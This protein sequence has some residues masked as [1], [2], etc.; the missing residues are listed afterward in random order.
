MIGNSTKFA[1]VKGKGVSKIS[2]MNALDKAMLSAGIGDINMIKVSS[3][4]PPEIERVEDFPDDIGAFRPCVIAK[5]VGKGKDLGAGLA[6]GFR[7]DKKGGYVAENSQVT[8]NFDMNKF[9]SR[10][11]KKITKMG[12]DRDIE[13]DG[14][15]TETIELKVKEDEF[16]C[17]LVVLVYLP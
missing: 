11:M 3:V 5:A 12:E 8:E 15:V 13:L 9:E 10:L 6:Y 1:L 7:K 17:A 4:L 14:F 2:K 16:G